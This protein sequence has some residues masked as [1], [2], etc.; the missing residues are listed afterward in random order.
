MKKLIL[1][2]VLSG[3]MNTNRNHV[4]SFQFEKFSDLDYASIYNDYFIKIPAC[5]INVL[6]TISFK[7]NVDFSGELYILKEDK[8]NDGDLNSLNKEVLKSNAI[9]ANIVHE[10]DFLFKKI[11]DDF[12]PDQ[13][14]YYYDDNANRYIYLKK[15]VD[16]VWHFLERSKMKNNIQEIIN[17][18]TRRIINRIKNENEIFFKKLLKEAKNFSKNW[19]GHYR[20]LTDEGHTAGGS[21]TGVYH[22]F[23]ISKDSVICRQEGYMA[24]N[25]IWYLAQENKDTLELYRY[26]ELNSGTFYKNVK[27]SL[28]YWNKGCLYLKEGEEHI[29][30]EKMDKN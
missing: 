14:C 8:W 29:K 20:Y 10:E 17:K 1:L 15:K 12:I 4:V 27:K 21:W 19:H 24:Y 25:K 13:P 23:Y 6:D 2:L 28:L 26:K 22:D 30:L 11:K 18:E 9:W 5:K 3:C 16:T 7:S